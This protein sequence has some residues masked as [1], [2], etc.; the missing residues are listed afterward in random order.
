[1]I[2][3]SGDN[4]VKH[5]WHKLAH[6]L[7]NKPHYQQQIT[8][9]RRV[10]FYQTERKQTAL[11]HIHLLDDGTAYSGFMSSFGGIE[12]HGSTLI[13][14]SL[15]KECL[16]FC[17][18]NQVTELKIRHW[19]ASYNPA[20]YN[21][22]IDALLEIGFETIYSDLN[23]HVPVTFW[24][25]ELTANEQRRLRKCQE[26]E[27]IFKQIALFNQPSEA[28]L[29]EYYGIIRAN[30]A[31]KGYALSMNQDQFVASIYDRPT[32]FRLFTV[33]KDGTTAALAL[34][35][36]VSPQILYIYLPADDY[37]FR[38]FSPNVMLYYEIVR[39]AAANGFAQVDYGTCS[40]EGILN[41]G[42]KKFKQSIGGYQTDKPFL[43]F[44][45]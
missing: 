44:R 28:E 45:F 23:Y 30:R 4:S 2:D 21:A 3:A 7:Y 24:A 34:C 15:Y 11:M 38:S 25:P 14:N 6:W 5:A 35:V 10:T 43:R 17:V 16:N 19:P 36:I 12:A 33:N 26:A 13:Y 18:A 39:W 40:L 31:H 37:K 27:F 20:H 8:A 22:S 1:M 9:G 41:E 42:L 29:I 32:D